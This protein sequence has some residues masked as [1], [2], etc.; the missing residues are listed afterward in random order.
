MSYMYI[1]QVKRTLLYLII[2]VGAGWVGKEGYGLK[3]GGGIIKSGWMGSWSGGG[4]GAV[5]AGKL[6][7]IVQNEQKYTWLK[8][9]MWLTWKIF[10]GILQNGGGGGVVEGGCN[11]CPRVVTFFN[12]VQECSSVF[13]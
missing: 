11:K 3:G 1:Y 8:R 4:G 2:T 13:L 12:L 10:M 9:K 7:K 6:S 5:V